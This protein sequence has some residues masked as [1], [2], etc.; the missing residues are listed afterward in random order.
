MA[1]KQAFLFLLFVI[2]AKKLH[3]VLYDWEDPPGPYTRLH[4]SKLLNINQ[5]STIIDRRVRVVNDVSKLKDAAAIFVIIL[6][7]PKNAIQRQ[8]TRT[9]LNALAKRDLK[10]AFV[11]GQTSSDIQVVLM[12]AHCIRKNKCI[13]IYL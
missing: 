1:G 7:A 3:L 12:H 8:M 11:I 13:V 9:T 6:S 2:L 4:A 5:S 10:W